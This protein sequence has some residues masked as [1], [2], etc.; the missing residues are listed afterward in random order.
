MSITLTGPAAHA[1]STPEQRTTVLFVVH[2]PAIDEASALVKSRSLFFTTNDSGD[3]GRVFALGRRGKTVGV[4]HWSKHPSDCEALAPGKPGYVWV[5]DIGDNFD[6]RSSISISQVPVGRGTRRVHVAKY[7]LVYPTGPIN[8]ETL[9]RDPTTGR[10]YI[11]TKDRAG[12]TL[13]EV[14]HHLSRTTDNV[15]RPIAPV[16]ALAT[17]GSFF[18]GGHYLVIRNYSRAALYA[19]PS[20]NRVGSFRLPRE[21]QGE[22]L[23]ADSDQSIYLAGEGVDEPVLQLRLPT[24]ARRT[25]EAGPSTA[26]RGF[27]TP[28]GG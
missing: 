18:P 4:T 2:D 3:S 14:P 15:L 10:L 28:V 24:W 7:P 26:A 1:A 6:R 19:W 25:L 27:P 8:A 17:D 9:V 16:L 12:G 20:M 21:H 22:G 13:Y 23:A 11:A 5:G